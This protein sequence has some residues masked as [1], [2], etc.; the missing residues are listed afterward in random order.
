[1]ILPDHR[2]VFARR[3]SEG[4]LGQIGQAGRRG[5][6]GRINPHCSRFLSAG[7]LSL[8]GK[9]RP[10]A[11]IGTNQAFGGGTG[12]FRRSPLSQASGRIGRAA[13]S[14]LAGS[15]AAVRPLD[16]R[17]PKAPAVHGRRPSGRGSKALADAA[18]RAAVERLAGPAG[19][20][21]RPF[22]GGPDVGL[23]G[24]ER[25]PAEV[26][27]GPVI[28][29]DPGN[30]P[31]L[32]LVPADDGHRPGVIPV[33]VPSAVMPSVEMVVND[34][35]RV[36]PIA[37]GAPADVIV[38]IV[39]V[40]PSRPPRPAM[41]RNPIPTQA[42]APAP[43]AVMR[44]A[45]APGLGGHPRP[46][47][48]RIPG[49]A[50]VII[51]PPAGVV[52]R[53]HPN[54]PVVGLVAPPAVVRQLIIIV[55]ISRGQ[56]SPAQAP[57]VQCVARFV[58]RLKIVPAGEQAGR[59]SAPPASGGRDRFPR[60]DKNGSVLAGRFGLA[61]VHGELRA[62]VRG[63]VQPVQAGLKDVKRRV[64]RMDL[65]ISLSVHVPDAEKDAALEKV[66]LGRVAVPAGKPGDVDLG[67]PI[68]AQDVA[69]AELDF[70]PAFPCSELVAFDDDEVHLA[71]LVTEVLSAL[72]INVAL[73]VAQPGE[74]PVVVALGLSESQE[75]KRRDRR[76][77]QGYEF[78]HLRLLA[79]S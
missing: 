73:D 30:G 63:D 67:L 75:R 54:I 8:S 57:G 23:G 27:A 58:P 20:G 46:A 55:G 76:D 74:A 38:M 13:G 59:P 52:N 68:K 28:K 17:G 4:A 14:H 48:D 11:G 19:Q 32:Q 16:F 78:F 79:I 44:G 45:P 71:E 47:D 60:A 40:N 29:G 35:D 9:G 66:D 25:N 56:I 2:L 33:A 64:G 1:M 22:E 41:H 10:P 62:A 3:R 7:R 53:R 39:P 77:R 50:A 43:P 36:I 42:V 72:E 37:E 61:A 5:G 34:D 21:R 69:P 18:E 31:V 15:R 6:P 26:E 51:R 24:P 70:R 65:E 49:P 12:R